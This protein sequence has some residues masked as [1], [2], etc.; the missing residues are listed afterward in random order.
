VRRQQEY[1]LENFGTVQTDRMEYAPL[2][3]VR[4]SFA[5][6][7]QSAAAYFVEVSDGAGRAYFRDRVAARNGVAGLTVTAGGTPGL[8]IIRV[9]MEDTSGFCPFRMGSF[10]L[11]ATTH[12]SAEGADIGEFFT[13][14][15][16]ALEASI[17]WAQY[18]GRWVAGDKAADNSPMNLAYPRFRLDAAIYLERA[19]TLKGH[20]DLCYAHQNPDGSL[21]DHIYA[22]G[23]PGWE[24]KRRIRSLM[25]D[26]ETGLIINVWQVWM[27]TG[28]TEWMA[29]LL[30]PMLHGW[31]YATS[32]P[33][34]WCAEL[35]LIK[36]PHAADEWDVQMGDGSCFRNENSRYVASLCDA[37]RMPRAADCLADML[38]AV[39]RSDEADTLRGLAVS[40]RKRANDLLWDGSKYRHHVHID[41]VDHSDFDE[42]GQ[43]VMSN[44]WACNDGLA[45]HEQAVAIIQE[46]ERR[47][48]ATGDTYPWWS[49][50]PGYPEGHFPRYPPGMYLNGGLFPWVGGQLCRACFQ[51]GFAERGWRLLREFW[52]RVKADGGACPT[53][54]TL[55]GR[56][57]ANT[58]WTTRYD[59]WG[60]ASWGQAAI[61]GLVGVVPLAPGMDRCRCVPQ[62]AAGGV[63]KAGACI[64]MPASRTYFAYEYA[65]VNGGTRFRFTGSGRSVDLRISAAGR[66]APS[67]ASLNGQPV[68][69][70]VRTIDGS[71][72]WC[73]SAEPAGV[74]ALQIG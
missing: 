59:A 71:E 10:V 32:S 34:L 66:G 29:S 73:L 33:D 25:A 5:C 60:I 6:R 51:H 72:Y 38:V 41:P 43:L 64:A 30:E 63:T 37:V 4:I 2:D 14:L 54:Y 31:K 67:E 13:W 35:G 8:H 46:Y 19:E 61:E 68:A 18:D 20:L 52:Q 9:F 50:Q 55:D 65:A 36:K 12:A 17:D 74:N 27:A 39:G 23:H 44:T 57:A 69:V 15:R 42:D 70:E 16:G 1:E 47:L 7:G 28:D 48:Q 40:A 62:W 24:G 11:E 22:D 3:E 26:L 49:L 58:P 45:S 53:W 21:H 56:A